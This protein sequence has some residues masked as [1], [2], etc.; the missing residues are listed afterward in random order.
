MNSIHHHHHH[1][2]H[3][4]R[5]YLEPGTVAHAFNLGSQKV[6]AGR[7]DLSQFEASLVYGE[8]IR[9]AKAI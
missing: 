7:S 1:H 9:T 5:F 2:Q 6:E 3:H 8:N 4:P